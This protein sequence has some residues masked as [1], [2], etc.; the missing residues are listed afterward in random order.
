MS[1]TEN[2]R[3]AQRARRR[4]REREAGLRRPLVLA[5][6]RVALEQAAR[7]AP[8]VVIETEIRAAIEAG[9]LRRVGDTAI[10]D[11]DQIGL[12]AEVARAT[13]PTT[14]RKAWRPIRVTTQRRTR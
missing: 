10:V 3:S 2:P 13:S 11:L 5:G 1:T 8:G 6:S 14:G 12:E 9:A 7:L 4:Q